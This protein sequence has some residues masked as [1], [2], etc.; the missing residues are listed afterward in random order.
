MALA[1]IPQNT[2]APS[3]WIHDNRYEDESVRHSNLL[4]IHPMKRMILRYFRQFLI[5]TVAT[6]FFFQVQRADAQYSDPDLQKRLEK[7]TGDKNYPEIANLITSEEASWKAN[8]SISYFQHMWLIG[9]ALISSTNSNS[10]WLGRSAVWNVL[11]KPAPN[12]VGDTRQTAELKR[13]GLTDA[14]AITSYVDGLNPNEFAAARHD[15]FL[16]LATYAQQLRK[17]LIPNYH[18]KFPGA[19]NDPKHDPMELPYRQNRIDNETQDE[20]KNALRWLSEGQEYYL[21]EAYSHDPRNDDELKSIFEI[22]DIKKPDRD[23]VW[24]NTR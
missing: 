22:L 23:K 6:G 9:E 10:Y 17:D 15:T 5:L 18:P 21:T 3:A 19:T 20:I 7:L 12:N 13:M 1:A 16:M 2:E 8:P 11:L 4:A 24:Q 14:Q